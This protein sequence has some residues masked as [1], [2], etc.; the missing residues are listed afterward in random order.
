MG[1]RK[2]LRGLLIGGTALMFGV[3]FAMTAYCLTRGS[4][5]VHLFP[6]AR[7]ASRRGMGREA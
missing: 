1:I 2:G 7:H 5:Q 6:C 3:I 4:L